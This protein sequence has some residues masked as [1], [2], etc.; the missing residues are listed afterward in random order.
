MNKLP[1]IQIEKAIGS[2]RSLARQA[3]SIASDEFDRQMQ[4]HKF[5]DP[6][7][8]RLDEIGEAIESAF[9]QLITLSEALQL[10]TL[11]KTVLETSFRAKRMNLSKIDHF[12][13]HSGWS[14]W[15]GPV[16]QL[17]DAIDATFGSP[18]R[19]TQGV[20]AY[21]MS[22]LQSLQAAITNKNCFDAPTN[23]DDVH[24]RSEMV[25][26]CI[27]PDLIRKPPLAKSIKG[28]IPDSGIP[29]L[30][31]LLEYKFLS[32]AEQAG[33]IADEIL[34]DTRGY[35]A[36]DWVNIVFVI[37][38]TKRF[39]TIYEWRALLRQCGVPESVQIILLHGEEPSP[40]S[41]PRQKNKSKRTKSAPKNTPSTGRK[42][43]SS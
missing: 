22:V 26:R 4:S 24:N 17:A 21:L 16:E 1:Q 40:P 14:H 31:T 10:G 5:P 28:F 19:S 33:S 32:K 25:L 18:Q 20:N 7:E 42:K 2:I 37:Y 6:H 12:E 13:D 43:R 34:A 29:S 41:S 3:N 23:E 39:K 30:L 38:E 15:A 8:S 9:I 11:H 27:F 35:E 36:S